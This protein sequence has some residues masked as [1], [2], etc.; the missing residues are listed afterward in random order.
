MKK[1]SWSK[2][3]G[4]GVFMWI[5]MAALVWLASYI[6][7]MG[8][9]LTQIVLVVLAFMFAYGFSLNILFTSGEQA[10]GYGIA[11][12]IVGFILD[13]VFTTTLYPALFSMWAYWTAY[14]AILIAPMIEST[15]AEQTRIRAHSHMNFHSSV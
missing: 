8:Y 7:I 9:L 5:I 1:F 15:S 13:L 6:G 4:Y 3:I 2:A 14:L 10:F 11:F 12:I